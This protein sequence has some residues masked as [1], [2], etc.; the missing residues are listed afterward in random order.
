LDPKKWHKTR[1]DLEADQV[2]DKMEGVLREASRIREASKSGTLTDEQR[3][4][5]TG[6]AAMALVN[7]KKEL[8]AVEDVN[9]ESWN[10]E[11]DTALIVLY[12][13]I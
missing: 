5:R 4:D 2:F 11:K 13:F 10:L 6:D 1:K 8:L 3:R 12:C 9:V 7:L